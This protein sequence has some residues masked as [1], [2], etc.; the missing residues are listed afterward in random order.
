MTL[1]AVGTSI[2]EIATS[3]SATRQ[4]KI[5]IAIGELVGSQALNLYLLLGLASLVR[6]VEIE[7]PK[8]IFGWVAFILGELMLLIWLKKIPPKL[9]A[10]I[11]LVTYAVYIAF[12]FRFLMPA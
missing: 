12:N 5:G 7:R 9:K 10:L 1:I 8:F 3:I 2:P 11:V 4:G 6:P